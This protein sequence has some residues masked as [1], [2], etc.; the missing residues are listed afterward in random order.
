MKGK[1]IVKHIIIAAL[2][3]KVTFL[4]V[5]KGVVVGDFLVVQKI[6]CGETQEP[7]PIKNIGANPD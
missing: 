1:I 3:V 5:D 2:Q 6:W 4:A 7:I